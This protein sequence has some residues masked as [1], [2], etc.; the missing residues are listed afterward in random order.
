MCR[1]MLFFG[2]NDGPAPISST[3]SLAISAARRCADF[4]ALSEPQWYYV[5]SAFH[6]V[7]F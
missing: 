2:T 5:D 6:I 3:V 7:N 1:P 4:D